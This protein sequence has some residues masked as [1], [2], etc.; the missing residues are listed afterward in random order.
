MR[1]RLNL[2]VARAREAHSLM[3]S[4]A[5]DGLSIGFRTL[6]SRR[7][8]RS[9]VRRLSRIDLWEVSLVTFPMLPQHA[10]PP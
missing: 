1:G 5:V 7:D 3:K 6:E 2:E 4:G 10:F 8:P 9:G